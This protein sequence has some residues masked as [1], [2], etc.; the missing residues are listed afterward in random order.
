MC[1]V[2]PAIEEAEKVLDTMR[3]TVGLPK[4]I[5]YAAHQ[6]LIVIGKYYAKSDECDAYRLCIRLSFYR[7]FIFRPCPRLIR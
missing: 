2:I 5:R 1:H 6:S 4:I 3:D 7:L